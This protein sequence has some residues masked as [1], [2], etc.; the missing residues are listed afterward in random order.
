MWQKPVEGAAVPDGTAVGDWMA[1]FVAQ[2]GQLEKANG[3][4]TDTISIIKNCED[5]INASR[6]RK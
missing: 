3:R 1:A 4:T 6:G 5:L 2:A